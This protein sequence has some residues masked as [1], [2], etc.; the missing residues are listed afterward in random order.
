[1]TKIL[2]IEDHRLISSALKASIENG[3][4]DARVDLVDSETAIEQILNLMEKTSYDLILLDIGIESIVGID[5]LELG[6]TIRSSFPKQKLAIITGYDKEFF[7][8]R[9][10]M[11][12][13]CDYILKNIKPRDLID[14]IEKCLEKS[15]EQSFENKKFMDLSED[16]ITII[17]DYGS[18]MD[19]E[20]LAKKLFISPRTLNNKISLIYEKLYVGNYREMFEKALELGIIK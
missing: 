7:R 14:R 18:G 16:E 20:D 10:R 6:Q 2:L 5:G 17:K 8:Y 12:G 3:L 1:M 9:A 13:A 15:T 4:K 11:I 19:K